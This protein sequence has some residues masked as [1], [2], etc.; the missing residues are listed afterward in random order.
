M[1]R[2]DSAMYFNYGNIQYPKAC[3]FNEVIP[4]LTYE[5]AS[6]YR[7]VALH[8]YTAQYQPNDTYPLLVPEGVPRPRDKRIPGR[9][10]AGDANQPGLHRITAELHPGDTKNNENH[11][12]GACF[13]EGPNRAEY[14][15]TGLPQRPQPGEQCDEYP[16]ASTLEGAAH[17]DWDFSVRA[18]PQRDNSVAG[19]LL[20]SYYVDDRILAW[21]PDLD[22]PNAANDRFYVQIR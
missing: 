19:G 5:I 22:Q 9:F 17:P 6:E 16:F 13:K 8:I 10:V 12:N 18:V 1:L 3:I 4:H 21:D 2:C 11:K 7:S 20:R 14:F 15:D